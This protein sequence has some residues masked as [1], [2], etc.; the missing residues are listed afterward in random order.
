MLF[1]GSKEIPIFEKLKED[2]D[3]HLRNVENN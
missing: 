2:F 3:P 1:N